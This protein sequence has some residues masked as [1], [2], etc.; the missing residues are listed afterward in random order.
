MPSGVLA[1]FAVYRARPVDRTYYVAST[2]AIRKGTDRPILQDDFDGED[3]LDR[4]AGELAAEFA[5][6]GGQAVPVTLKVHGF[7]TRRKHFEQELLAD[8]DPGLRSRSF[9]KKESPTAHELA[10]ESFRPDGRFYIAFRWPS[11]GILSRGSLEDAGEAFVRSPIVGFFLV[12]VPLLALL[13]LRCLDGFL[14]ACFPW[15]AGSLDAVLVWGRQLW[16]SLQAGAPALAELMRILLTPYQEACVAATLL[17]AGMLL[18]TLRV[19]TYARD[20][21]RALH[22][23]VPDLGEFMRALEERLQ[24]ANVKVELDVVGHSMGALVLINAFRIMSDYFH[25]PLAPEDAALGRDGTFQLR[26]L[27]LCAPDLPAVMATPDRNN[28][29]LSALRRFRSLHIFCSDRDIILKWLSSLANWFSEP[30]HDMAGRRLGIVLLVRDRPTH[31]GTPDSRVDW[32]LLPVTRPALRHFHLYPRDPIVNESHPAD[33]HFHDCTRDASLGGVDGHHL[34]VAILVSGLAFWLSVSI[35]RGL[36]G[37]LLV[38]AVLLLLLGSL[39]RFLWPWARDN[40]AL[41]GIVGYL[42][43]WP[44]LLMFV[45]P[46]TS[47][48]PHGGYFAF[49][50]APRRRIAA[51]LRDPAA[52]PARNAAGVEL[53]EAEPAPSLRYKRVRL[54]V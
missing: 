14:R 46:R 7:N 47:G 24:R 43:D 38:L 37:W 54:S 30:R 41:R 4:L 1:N 18:L 11:E 26:T 20:H 17:G 12:L 25:G 36:F 31:L 44:T 42:A 29:F 3:A 49:H 52:F 50:H 8:A 22:Y 27:V 53:D 51:I 35:C 6:R 48:N 45:T 13:W 2:S 19:S 32:R 5:A 10:A 40:K 34:G 28:Y 16:A 21:Y 9:G 15:T 33:L 39:C 23:G